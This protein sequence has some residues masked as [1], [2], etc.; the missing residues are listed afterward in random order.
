MPKGITIALDPDVNFAT[1]SVGLALVER[2]AAISNDPI[3]YPEAQRHPLWR[4]HRSFD[5][6]QNRCARTIDLTRSCRCTRSEPRL[7]RETLAMG[8][9]LRASSKCGE[10]HNDTFDDL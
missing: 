3:Q 7:E 4:H 8:S 10:R 1:D 9:N 6:A 5:L 2:L